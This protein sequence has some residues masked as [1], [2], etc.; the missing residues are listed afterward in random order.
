[1][2]FCRSPFE[3]SL[4]RA[5]LVRDG[6]LM[7]SPR[8]LLCVVV[9]ALA[10]GSA[11][12]AKTTF[13]SVWKSPDA[14]SVSFG[15][16]KVVAIVIDADDSLRVAGEE[17]LARE[18]TARGIQGVPSYK[19]IPKELLT[20]PVEAKAWFERAAVQGVVAFRVVEKERR[21]TY[22]PATWSSSYYSTLW[23]YYGYGWGAVYEPGHK[24]DDSFVSLETL[25]FSV[26]RNALV[27]A[28]ISTTEKPKNA[29][30]VVTEV[31]KEA[32]K[33]MRKQG[34]DRSP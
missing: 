26:P 13:S 4:V 5:V 24:R 10:C 29:Q 32:A 28:G 22:V 2:E 33:E 16:Q 21:V 14:A 18:L 15:G 31:V 27:W 11:L 3:A 9:T 12:A 7:R 34:L 30:A 23:G 19:F 25:I 20:N 1:L 8:R 6:R 17:A